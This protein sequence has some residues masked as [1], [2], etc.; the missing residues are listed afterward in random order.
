MYNCVYLHAYSE[1]QKGPGPGEGRREGEQASALGVSQPS[2]SL[3]YLLSLLTPPYLSLSSRPPLPRP[4][5]PLPSS[6]SLSVYRALPLSV[7]RAPY[8]TYCYALPPAFLIISL[9][10]FALFSRRKGERF[11][12]EREWERG[13]GGGGEKERERERERERG[14]GGRRSSSI[15]KL[16]RFPLGLAGWRARAHTRRARAHTRRAR[17]HT[18]R[19]HANVGAPRLSWLARPQGRAHACTHKE[20]ERG[21]THRSVGRQPDRQTD[22]QNARSAPTL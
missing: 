20:S 10:F 17:A 15:W 3:C 13:R 1:Y 21:R 6:L 2:A 5:P 7:P 22:R 9:L 18:R 4:P 14:V 11:E 19:A 16:E 12:R 8:H